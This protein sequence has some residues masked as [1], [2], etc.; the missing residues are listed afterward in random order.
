MDYIDFL[1]GLSKPSDHALIFSDPD[2]GIGRISKE[3]WRGFDPGLFLDVAMP[4]LKP[5]DAIILF[6]GR[7][8]LVDLIIECR[9]RKLKYYDLVWVKDRTTGHLNAKKRPMLNHEQLLVIYDKPH[10]YNPQRWEGIKPHT[11]GKRLGNKDTDNNMY[12]G[13]LRTETTTNM[14]YPRTAFYHKAV[15]NSKK[16]YPT[17]KPVGL[18]EEIIKNYTSPKSTVIDMC[19]GSGSTVV[20]AERL[21]LKNIYNDISEEAISIT[22]F[23]L[24][25]H[26]NQN[27]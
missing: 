18:C 14:K 2:Y 11:I 21:G 26:H 10:F 20:A 4:L 27:I 5:G 3:K 6:C 13:Y 12:G 19:C 15:T 22:Q 8:L 23:R 1:D 25:D 16:V 24:I 17:Q 7:E 9:S